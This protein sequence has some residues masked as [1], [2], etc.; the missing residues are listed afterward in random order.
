[1][2]K[3]DFQW[4]EFQFTVPMS[5]RYRET[6]FPPLQ[7]GP[8]G[9]IT[10]LSRAYPP[11]SMP[12][13]PPQV[14]SPVGQPLPQNYYHPMM[15]HPSLLMPRP[16]LAPAPTFPLHGTP[17]PQQL[18]TQPVFPSTLPPP[19]QRQGQRTPQAT[20]PRPTL[21]YHGLVHAPHWQRRD[22]TASSS[23]A[24]NPGKLTLEKQELQAKVSI[25]QF[26][27]VHSDTVVSGF[28]VPIAHCTL[29][30]LMW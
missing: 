9:E 24:K 28:L 16:M 20:P 10:Y 1:M 19:D 11:P 17:F 26:S 18:Y 21:H 3:L 27:I 7:R 29:R 8:F 22:H 4:F 2:S 6:D 23:A 5:Y 14:F 15:P 25:L 30:S 13:D 12:W